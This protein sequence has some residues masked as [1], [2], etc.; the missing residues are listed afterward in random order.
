M[1]RHWLGSRAGRWL[2]CTSAEVAERALRLRMFMLLPL[3][4]LALGSRAGRWLQC[5]S[6]E[7]ALL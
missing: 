5:T 3:H 4:V 1:P 6:A 2:Q 7:L